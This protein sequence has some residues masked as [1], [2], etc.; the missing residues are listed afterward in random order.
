MTKM[1]TEQL[2]AVVDKFNDGSDSKMEV[3]S[4]AA[5]SQWRVS[6]KLTTGVVLINWVSV[7]DWNSDNTFKDVKLI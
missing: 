2:K 5:Y 6:Y 3:E 4:P 1:T 7:S